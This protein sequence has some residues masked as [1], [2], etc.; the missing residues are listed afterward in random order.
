MK[1]EVIAR[2]KESKLSWRH[3]RE[4]I[5]NW[6]QGG[7]DSEKLNEREETSGPLSSTWSHCI[8]K[9]LNTIYPLMSPLFICSSKHF[10]LTSTVNVSTCSFCFQSLSRLFL[11]SVAKSCL[12]LCELMN[13][14][15]SGFPVLHCFPEFAQTHVHW[16]SDAIQPS[17]P[18]SPP[19]PPAF[20]LSQHQSLFQWVS[21]S[22]QV[23]KGLGLQLQYQ[24]F[25][26]T[27]R[28][29]FL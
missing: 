24:S 21:S 11:V 25:Q 4:I 27:F 22:F 12:T 5:G 7:W 6:E 9:V 10:L 2:S 19:S 17:H 14:S 29:D 1:R 23:A 18:L 15:T 3:N 26:W 13:Y 8:Q 28:T 16:V 20:S